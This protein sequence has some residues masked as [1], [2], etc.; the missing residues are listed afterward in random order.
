MGPRDRD[1]C[2]VWL[3]EAPCAPVFE[4]RDTQHKFGRYDPRTKTVDLCDLLKFHGHLCGGLV[5]SAVS[6]RALFDV[7]FEDGVVDRTELE[8]VSSNSACVGDVAAYLT[9]ARSRFNTHYIDKALAGGEFV[10][11]RVS[12]GRTLHVRL[13]PALYPAATRELSR[14]IA[15]GHYSPADI[16]RFRDLQ[17]AY[18]RELVNRPAQASFH[19]DELPAFEPPEQPCRD[20]GRRRDNDM[21]DVPR[22]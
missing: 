13:D 9:G 8:I 3:R 17:W 10:V 20:L 5:E 14:Q 6:L 22:R 12:T 2:P 7:M 4:V 18:A 19:V 15:A 16:D 1:G 21:K 11:H